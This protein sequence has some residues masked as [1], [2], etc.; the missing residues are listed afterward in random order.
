V[1]AVRC[2]RHGP[3]EQ[4]TVEE[5][6]DPAA[7][8][9]DVVVDVHA[10]GVNFTDLLFVADGYQVSVPVPFTPGSEFAGVVSAVGEH[11]TGVAVGDRVAGQGMTGAFAERVSRPAR[12]VATL[13]SD[14]D[15]VS[16]AA[17]GV[18]FST[19]Y[20]ALRSAA[21]LRQGEWLAVTG[22]A[23]GVGS[24]GVVLGRALGAKVLALV[25]SPRKS[26]FCLGLGAD[27]ALDLS[28]TTDVRARIRE[29][30]GGPDVVLDQ[31]GGE[32]AEVL[33]RST[34]RRG[35]FVTVGFA[36][37]V[38]PR[39]P[40]NL[41]LLKDVTVRGFEIR[42]F[43][44]HEPAAA[45]RDA[46]ELAAL[47]KKGVGATVTARFP[48]ERAAAALRTVADRAATGK[49]VLTTAAGRAAAS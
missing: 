25:S 28:S 36:S 47:R 49:V 21:D 18:T 20:S 6:P 24:A 15:L 32:L 41:V 11:V 26:A 33:L 35:R 7:G 12:S 45:A 39:I 2:T 23:G 48:L 16:A 1:I 44:E 38:I 22:A 13:A 43:A 37:G 29:L 34:R 31:V 30:C 3:P 46:A 9:D 27:A 40:L 8:P 17:T 14:A 10:A 5:L 19:A 4:L 42:G